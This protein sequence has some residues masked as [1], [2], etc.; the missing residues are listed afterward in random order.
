LRD[1]L[2][3]ICHDFQQS[4]S[5]PNELENCG[6]VRCTFKGDHKLSVENGS[7]F[8]L[9]HFLQGKME[10]GSELIDMMKVIYCFALYEGPILCFF[11]AK[12]W[13]FE[14]TYYESKAT[15]YSR[16]D[17]EGHPSIP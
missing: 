13:L 11:R 15:F 4:R 14:I 10:S 6:A 3:P 9:Q 12:M 5:V 1:L 2:C 17:L 8:H 16:Q 7:R